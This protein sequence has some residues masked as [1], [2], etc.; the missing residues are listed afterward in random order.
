MLNPLYFGT[1]EN[2]SRRIPPA[3]AATAKFIGYAQPMIDLR[4]FSAWVP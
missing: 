2:V 4:D 1:D 3:S